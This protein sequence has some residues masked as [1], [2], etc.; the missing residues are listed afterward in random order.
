MQTLYFRL[1]GT[2]LDLE[3]GEVD[4]EG[5]RQISRRVADIVNE[6]LRE[7]P[8]PSLTDIAEGL[9]RAEESKDWRVR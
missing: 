7:N 8:N 9:Y 2:L 1:G 6:I 4:D 3:T 5:A